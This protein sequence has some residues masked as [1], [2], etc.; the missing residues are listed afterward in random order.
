[1]TK[2]RILIVF[3]T[4]IFTGIPNLC[5][6][7]ERINPQVVDPGSPGKTQVREYEAQFFSVDLPGRLNYKKFTEIGIGKI[8][9]RVFQDEGRSGGLFFRSTLFRTLE[10]R[11]EKI[12]TEI[13]SKK[14]EID[15]DLCA[16]MI[17]R[18]FNWITRSNF[19]DYQYRSGSRQLVRKFDVFNPEAVNRIVEIFKELA[20]KNIDC[21]LIQD[22]FFLRYNEGF[23]NWGKAAFAKAAGLP[24][25][26]NLMML[27][28]SPYNKK[29]QQVKREQLIKVLTLIIKGCK[30]VNP[31]IKIGMNIYY[32]TPIFMDKGEA[33]YAHNLPEIV[34]TGIDYI[35]LMSY[36]RQIKEELRL[37]ESDS[38]LMF[39][40]ILERAYEICK[41]KLIAKLQIRDWG[42]GRRIPV[43]E[44][45]AYLAIIPVGIKR[46]C[47]TP[48]KPGDLDYLE[49][50][51]RQ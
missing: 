33:W 1:M 16:W 28:N 23:S 4:F 47:F 11:L 38:R 10:P 14:Q 15:I 43:S 51:T 18:R 12:I 35:Y 8:I 39:R 31:K 45:R 19:F 48:V 27:S 22:D 50:L 29:W 40:R 26:E 37:T 30:Q 9:V 41:D 3:I 6:N 7:G 42:T 34:T 21:I 17:T 2:L 49:E 44:G 32:E 24:A 13:N 46:V 25:K 5:K 36:H 20:A